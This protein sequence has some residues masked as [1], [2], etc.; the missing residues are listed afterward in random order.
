MHSY[1]TKYHVSI[2]RNDETHTRMYNFYIVEVFVLIDATED[3][4]RSLVITPSNWK[5]IALIPISRYYTEKLRHGGAYYRESSNLY[6][7]YDDARIQLAFM[8]SKLLIPFDEVYESTN[9][10]LTD[11]EYKSLVTYF[12][13]VFPEK[14][15]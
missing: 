2:M 14:Y 9:G 13:E 15:I 12:Y 5:N 4:S 3:D 8:C 7:L 1:E 10:V 11:N 6:S